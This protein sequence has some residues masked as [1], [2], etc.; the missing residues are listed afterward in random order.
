MSKLRKAILIIGI[1]VIAVAASLA[2]ALA[3]YAT[4]SMKTD[5]IEL[6]FKLKEPAQPKVYDGTPLKLSLV[7]FDDPSNSDIELSKGS[8]Q[9]GHSVRVEFT[10]SQTNVGTSMSD[11]NVKIYD[12]NG[13]NVTNEYSIKVHGAP[14]TVIKRAIS[15]ELPAQP[16]VYNGT[17]VLFDKYEI[18]EDS[19]GD[20]CSGHKIYGSTDAALLNVGDTLP[21]DLKPLI[22]DIVGND[23]T[24]NYDIVDFIIP[25][26]ENITVIPRSISVRPVAKEKVYDGEELV[27]DEI[28]FV[29]GSLVE[30]QTLEFVIN[31]GGYTDKITDVGTV[32]TR[33]TTL[34]IYA[35]VDGKTVDVTENYDF[36][37]YE[38]VEHLTVTPR[39]LTVVAKS[40]TYVYNGEEQSYDGEPE[41]E[42]VEGLIEG[43]GMSVS[44]FGSR[45][46]VGVGVNMISANVNDNYEITCI[47]GTIEIT[48]YELVITTGS[49][50]KY[51]D[52]SA[53]TDE[54][55][56]ACELANKNHFIRNGELP[57]ITTVGKISNE[58][59]VTVRDRKNGNEDVTANYSITYEYGTLTVKV[60]PVRV[61]LENGEDRERV[62]FDGTAHA[63][64]IDDGSYFSVEPLL[65][66]GEEV[67]AFD[68]SS[69]DFEVVS[70]SREMR[71]AGEYYYK[72]K[73]KD[74]ELEQRQLYSNYELFV[75]ESGVL[76]IT[77]LP[78]AVSLKEYADGDAFTY[79]CKAVKLNAEEAIKELTCKT[80]LPDGV[81][82]G[83]LITKK[84]FAI[85]AEEIIDAGDDY[86][87]T[88]KI[89][90]GATA[91]NFDLTVS[92]SGL[93]VVNLMPVTVT[94]ADAERTYNGKAQTVGL[95]EAVV[96]IKKTDASSSDDETG[97]NASDLVII[98]SSENCVDANDYTFTVE[99]ARNRTKN[100]YDITVENALNADLD[101]GKLTIN[102]FYIEVTTD[103]REFDFDGRKHTSGV[104]TSGRLANKTHEIK[105][106]TDD[107]DLP[108]VTY[109]CDEL[110]QEI[111]EKNVFA[112]D[113]F[114]G[115]KRVTNN[116]EISYTYG[117]LSVK[118]ISLTVKTGDLEKVYCGTEIS[119]DEAEIQTVL[120]GAMSE[121][122][123]RIATGATPVT[124]TEV[125]SAANVFECEILTGG[126]KDVTGNFDL[127][128]VYGTLKVTPLTIS[129]TLSDFS[130]STEMVYDG[131]PKTF[132]VDDAI[133]GITD[134]SG[135]EYYII[136]QAEKPADGISFTADDFEI[137]YY[138]LV[139]DAGN[140]MYS[141]RF[142][143]DAFAKNFNVEGATSA[144][145][146]VKKKPIEIKL[147]NYTGEKALTFNN[148]VQTMS[149]TEAVGEIVGA[150][151][152]DGNELIAVSDL[153][154]VYPEELFNAGDYKYKVKISSASVAKNF[155]YTEPEADVTVNKYDLSVTLKDIELTFNGEEQQIDRAFA[156]R[157]TDATSV[158]SADDFTVE[159]TQDGAAATLKKS[160]N[161]EYTVT[162]ANDNFNIKETT[163]GTVKIKKYKVTVTLNNLSKQYDGEEHDLQPQNAIYAVS[164]S[165]FDANDF[166]VSYADE[167]EHSA[168][169]EYN[170]D[171]TLAAVHS[172]I[173]GDV[174]IEVKNTVAKIVKRVITITTKTESFVYDGTEHSSTEATLTGAVYGHYA[175]VTGG[176]VTVSTVTEGAVINKCAY[177]VYRITEGGEEED[178]TGNYVIDEHN[179]SY[180]TLTVTPRPVKLT[181]GSARREYTGENL[182]NNEVTPDG[183]LL[184]ELNHVCWFSDDDL[185][186]VRE[187]EEKENRFEVTIINNDTGDIVTENYAIEYEYGKLEVTPA[188]IKVTF[189]QKIEATYG[190]EDIALAGS[191]VIETIERVAGGTVALDEDDFAVIFYGGVIDAGE[192]EFRVEIMSGRHPDCYTVTSYGKN[193]LTVKK[194]ELTVTLKDYVDNAYT[195]SVQEVPEDSVESVSTTPD[196][197]TADKF[198]FTYSVGMLNVGTYG[199]GA[200]LKDAELARNYIVTYEQEGKYEIVPAE[201]TVTLQNYEKTYNGKTF[202]VEASQAITAITD[203]EGEASTLL[204]AQDF[205]AVYHDELRLANNYHERLAEGEAYVGETATVNGYEC[206]IL[207]P[208]TYTYGVRITDS[209]KSKNFVINTV[210]G[211]FK[212]KKR[213][214]TF[215]VSNVYMSRDEYAV[216]ENGPDVD[217]TENVSVSLNTPLAEGDQ[218]QVIRAVANRSYYDVP[219]FYLNALDEYV[220][221]NEGC[222]EFT[223]VNGDDLNSATVRVIVT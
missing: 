156:L 181:T 130:A 60:L 63:P 184:T 165:L 28:E 111:S 133:E 198:G 35:V 202:T 40:A 48:P 180:G 99:G 27:A 6:E 73:F 51:Y 188:A 32:D 57:S 70:E 15:V 17:K 199:Y 25:E 167:G 159:V 34:K 214:L 65:P 5:P 114:E 138:S 137:V 107:G 146:T 26:R 7:D 71:N 110:K 24:E 92:G 100:N 190:G 178:V 162:L 128:Y 139:Q 97:L 197:V 30:G 67:A 43:D 144:I 177:G 152:A 142:T 118:R 116:Y 191:D 157:F 193:V 213:K 9:P 13:F 134:A 194:F 196:G 125:G 84:D 66:D 132:A 102:R 223:N 141:V 166:V 207:T 46:D 18:A 205:T 79:S 50:E 109:V 88:V 189:K 175:K 54:N 145:V 170:L 174:E 98:Y 39:P 113:I 143:D 89:A 216:I 38:Y 153:T 86:E 186:S 52:G 12:Q 119:N 103:T 122:K 8:L 77:P 203:S 154:V 59:K 83:N 206:K 129:L 16:V 41:A 219:T 112:V 131:A 69:D 33:I 64:T 209:E 56:D 222:Y 91:A 76:E 176:I 106:A 53:L 160:G 81:V 19:E 101:H 1:L 55:H 124:L 21:R 221:T 36:N 210:G 117:T 192:Y 37:L 23:V 217:V 87:Y 218:L 96:G 195:G 179:S 108:S 3:L 172:D 121:Y 104:F 42:R 204:T 80:V 127:K 212:I 135:N 74:G 49:A 44:Y 201:I 61:T 215:S 220:L 10:G 4:G 161:Y 31:E 68:L 173:S 75:P 20:L 147:N 58:Y 123:A 149:V 11:A 182:T 126:N 95:A 151:G 158:L 14:L 168:F 150:A 136:G 148:R 183:G 163:G 185:P 90:D 164:G 29:D 187:V 72:V 211:T 94:L 120:V 85:D 208:D 105:R 2:T 62:Y 78:I 82:F 140:Y 93:V 22:Y 155:S 169:G 171:A 115:T 45:K 200:E 47:H